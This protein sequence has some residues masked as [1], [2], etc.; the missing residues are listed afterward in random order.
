MATKKAKKRILILSVTVLMLAVGVAGV[1][2]V[3]QWHRQQ[4]DQLT[5]ER[6]MAAYEEG[7]HAEALRQFD[8]YLQLNGD[9]AEAMYFSAKSRLR[10]KAPRNG[11]IA[12][13]MAK[14]RRV[15]D[16]QPDHDQARRELLE[17]YTVV[18]RSTEAKKLAEQILAQDA[19]DPTGLR[20]MALSLFQM[21][22]YAE[23]LP[24]AERYTETKGSSPSL[25]VQLII[26]D[27]LHNLDRPSLDLIKATS[28]ARQ[29][30]PNDPRVDLLQAYTY[31]LL[32][33]TEKATEWLRKAASRK[34]PN[35]IY[36]AVLIRLL[37]ESRLYT[38]SLTV[39]QRYAGDD[40]EA[41]V[42]TE[43]VQR[44]WELNR[45]QEVVDQLSD[46]DPQDS[47]SDAR[48]LAYQTMSLYQLRQSEQA[49]AIAEALGAR[50]N[51]PDAQ[52]WA[53]VLPAVFGVYRTQ[54]Q[55]I[56][57]L[58]KSALKV[59]PGNPRFIALLGDAYASMGENK[60]ALDAWETAMKSRP[61]WVVPRIR[62]AQAM[63]AA[64]EKKQAL[65][66]SVIAVRMAPQRVDAA[67]VYAMVRVANLPN[68]ENDSLEDVLKLVEEI[69]SKVPGEEKTLTLQVSLL[70]DASRKEEAA[71]VLKT[72]LEREEISEKTLHRLAQLS[73]IAQLGLADA[74]YQRLDQKG[75]HQSPN[76]VLSQAMRLASQGKREQ[77]LQ[78]L[79]SA[80]QVA[81]PGE[82]IEW[83]LIRVRYLDAT[84]DQRAAALWFKLADDNPDDHRIQ[85]LALQARS[86]QFDRDFLDRI[87]DRIRNHSGETAIGWRMARTRW[88]LSSRVEK[89]T[90]R[91]VDMLEQIVSESPNSVEARMLLATGLERMGQIPRAITELT[92]AS[93]QWPESS[94][95]VLQLARLHQIQRDFD[96]A[97]DKLTQVLANE[98]AT[99]GQRRTASLMLAQQGIVD[100]AIEFLESQTDLA[101]GS[102][103]Q[104]LLASLY[105][106]RNDLE[107]VEALCQEIIRQPTAA[108]IQFVANYYAD[109]GRKDDV[110]NVLDMLEQIKA[111][112]ALI[113]SL[114]G[115]FATKDG[116]RGEGLEHLTNAV[117]AAPQDGFHRYR[118][119]VFHLA[120]GQVD[121][122]LDVAADGVKSLPQDERLRNFQEHANWVKRFGSHGL[123]RPIVVAL[124]G[125]NQKIAAEVFESIEPREGKEQT[126]NQIAIKLRQKADA[127]PF[128]LP[129]QNVMS[130]LY[131]LLKQP[132][133]AALIATRAANSFPNAIEPVWLAAEALAMA[134]RWDEALL[135]SKQWQ[136]RSSQRHLGSDILMAEA[137][138]RLGDA[139]EAAQQFQPHLDRMMAEPERY[140]REIVRYARALIAVDKPDEA[141]E[142]LSPLLKRSPAWRAVWMQLAVLAVKNPDVAAQWLKQLASEIPE[143]ALDTQ[144][145][146]VAAWVSLAQRLEQPRFRQVARELA[147]RL[148]ENPDAT[149][150]TWFVRGTLAMK[151]RDDA[152]AETSYRAALKLDANMHV[153]KNNLAILLVNKGPKQLAEAVQ[154]AEQVVE[155]WP[156]NPNYLDTLA[157]VQ[158]QASNYDAAVESLQSAIEIEP[159]NPL[160]RTNLVKILNIAGRAEEAQKLESQNS[161]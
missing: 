138:L 145:G 33:D 59:S 103:D 55:R 79:E 43:L 118:L 38:E 104:V 111:P 155:A 23:A 133:D 69:Q 149:A 30:F 152:I 129:L 13:T 108:G 70:I 16:L 122:A 37:D 21:G 28:L 100:K 109:Q 148:V 2:M 105:L 143:D 117:N 150:R 93:Y 72:A 68:N 136:N 114:R 39:L 130:Q 35:D 125:E 18:R 121:E 115:E 62:R 81:Q 74:C 91:A 58:C 4:R 71:E 10:I 116:D 57:D 53:T 12:I 128:F 119:I 160:W 147:D 89:D 49:Q 139:Q 158:A 19:V 5:R 8:R 86:V 142:L 107:K 52:A 131:L 84:A 159:Q 11:H 60:L 50:T 102:S 64:G 146:L 27:I 157:Q 47:Q 135:M 20:A 82:E 42:Q 17:L 112:P 99:S 83:Q 67:V 110:Q 1:Y 75:R 106:Q 101:S 154:L 124:L 141:A 3:R 6:A 90:S 95:I 14:L 88:L 61:I 85:R 22:Q 66:E 73:D 56:V 156:K 15:L 126:L 44:L 151:S 32:K 45:H 123:F 24:F 144:T 26:L 140:V 132:N 80:Q 96:R 76:L 51:D 40:P 34:A 97:K 46:L 87:I 48:L 161:G 54:P 65:V 25:P 94:N 77:G 120:Q 78:L 9:D 7:K 31:R 127:N 137:K 41:S 92:A 29:K 134:E 98:L 153:A 113:H 36:V 63:L